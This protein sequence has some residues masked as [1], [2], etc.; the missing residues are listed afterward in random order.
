MQKYK[1]FGN[2]DFNCEKFLLNVTLLGASSYSIP[3][4]NFYFYNKSAIL[5]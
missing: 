2:N 1:F 5:P 3:Y 4:S